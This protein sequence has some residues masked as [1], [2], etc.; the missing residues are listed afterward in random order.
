[1]SLSRGLVRLLALICCVTVANVYY[2]Q[3]LLHT[4]SGDLRV[5]ESAVGLVVTATQAG[6][7]AG[8]VLVVPLGD[9]LPRRPLFTVLLAA[10]SVALA[11]TA[12]A[13]G[14][15]T[16]T[17]AAV[18][19]G[20]SS[21]VV[22]MVIPY[23]ATLATDEQRARIIGTLMG[24]VL[25][26]VLLSRTFAGVVASVAG[27]RG[28]YVVAACLMAGMAV[29]VNRVLPR[30]GREVGIGY[31]AQLRTVV[32]LARREPVL[33]LRSSIGAMQFAAFSCFWTTVTF[34][35]AGDPYHFSQAGIGVFALVGA[36]GAGC[37]MGFGR[38]L[39]RH[40]EL[41]W[42]ITGVGLALLLGSF[43]LL[44]A[45][46]YGLVW[47]V[48]GALLMDA[49]SQAVHVTN[50]AVIYDLVA[51]ARSRVTTI[52][53]TT[54]FFDGAVGATTGTIAY[55]HLGWL[56]A[57]G[58]AAASCVVGLVAWLATHRHERSRQLS[59]EG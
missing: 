25:L 13:P 18:F 27:W 52:Y 9:I 16:L 48:L 7:A 32:S 56:G 6:F 42:S 51:G 59:S 55:T 40:R 46:V 1:M 58:V 34:L 36:A 37:A 26:G 47:L 3:P 8:L 5:G 30:R 10:D 45:G 21:V 17:I 28:V 44:A 57:C 24:S 31:V 20:L 35:L 22:Q 49:C 38:V 19:V 14:L 2:V 29:V 12:A 43:A 39:D 54:Y 41:R 23:G 4:I 50:Q 53:M 15:H 11:A 33:R